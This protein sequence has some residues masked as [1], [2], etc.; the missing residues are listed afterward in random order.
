MFTAAVPLYDYGV[1]FMA[2]F[3][4]PGACSVLLYKHNSGG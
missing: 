1:V 3:R 2:N 4:G